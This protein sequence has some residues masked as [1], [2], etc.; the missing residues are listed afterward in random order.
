M[1]V[2]ARARLVLARRPWVYWAVVAT[3]AALA[4][5]AVQQPAWHRSM[6]NATGGEPLDRCWLL[7][8]SH[9]PGDALDGR[10]RRVAGC[11]SSL[12]TRSSMPRPA[13]GSA[14][15]WRPARYSP[16]STSPTSP[17]RRRSPSRARWW[18]R[19]PTRSPAASSPDLHVEVAADGLVLAD[20]ATVTDVVDDVIFVAV[21]ARA[22][23]P[24]SQQPPSRASP[25]CCISPD[26]Y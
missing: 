26:R 13:A 24:R 15:G 1:H 2:A 20:S 25:A 23:P 9:E 18:L 8:S 6:P 17:G 10:A 22:T 11:G 5:V 7:A 4:V 12:P 21:A 19:C 16:P 3:F 14:S